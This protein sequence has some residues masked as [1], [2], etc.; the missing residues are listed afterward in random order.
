MLYIF[1]P[2]D[3]P[4]TDLRPLLGGKG[5]GLLGI[6]RAGLKIATVP[7]WFVV[8][9]FAF[10]HF[11]SPSIVGSDDPRSLICS[12]PF[13]ASFKEE[14]Q[15][16]IATLGE[17]PFAVRSS[18]VFEDG[19]NASFA[20]QLSSELFVLPEDVAQAVRKVWASSFTPHSLDYAKRQGISLAEIKVAV[21]VQQM[22]DADRA[23]VVFSCDPVTGDRSKTVISSVYGVGEGLVSGAL[24][25]D[26]FTIREGVIDRKLAYKTEAFRR[27]ADN[28]S[29]SRVEQVPEDLQ[30][31]AS[32]S[33]DE[34]LKI[35]TLASSLME[36]FGV[37]QDVEWCIDGKGKLY[38]LQSRPITSLASYTNVAQAADQRIIWDNSNIVESYSGV[39]TPLTFSFVQEVYSEVYRQFVKVMGVDQRTVDRHPEA[40]TMLGFIQGRIYYNL[41]SWHRLISLLPFYSLNAEFMEQ[42]MGVKDRLITEPLIQ[43]SSWSTILS[44]PSLLLNLIRRSIELPK[45]T[46]LFHQHLDATLE[47]IETTDRTA[48]EL[49]A[50]YR[51][52]ETALLRKWTTPIV[53]DF[54][55]M[56]FYGLLKKLTSKWLDDPDG[57]LQNDLLT[58]EGGIIS[59]E[60]I[61]WMRRIGNMI[62][63]DAHLRAQ[64]LEIPSSDVVDLLKSYT[65]IY[66]HIEQY[67]DK[68]GDRWSDELKIE[69]ITPRLR[70]S[71]LGG[72]IQSTVR[73]GY[74]DEV[75]SRDKELGIRH[76]AEATAKKHLNDSLLRREVFNFVLRQAR[77]RVKGRE[78]L[79][80]E[81]TRVFAAVRTIFRCIG[82]RFRDRELISDSSDI[83]YL[84]KNEIFSFIEGTSSDLDLRATVDRR[85]HQHAAFELQRVPNR[86]ETFGIVYSD[87][88]FAKSTS[89][90]NVVSTLQG[91]G[92]CAGIVRARVKI[93]RDPAS[94]GDMTGSI[95][96]AERTDPGWAPIFPQVSGIIVERGS[97][98]SHSAI[99]ARELG[100]PTVVGIT[101][102]MSILQDGE[103]IEIDGKLGIIRLLERE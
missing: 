41:L 35:A 28:G 97:L 84:T 34:I 44:M 36:V 79:R 102:L 13:D 82:D 86:L 25:S 52:L 2:K 47:S 103:M 56:I 10:A 66:A 23:G 29:G 91:Q 50:E 5:A 33:D 95:L 60:P 62:I 19:A 73:S 76:A 69:T 59:T 12:T 67:I 74:Y 24:D 87:N 71:L 81:R 21:I 98:L 63:A 16:A 3:D 100:I 49:L 20:G 90:E 18:A 51:K 61:R 1:S 6:E 77:E 48:S 88:S 80:F 4:A 22:I 39:T 78:N 92:C 40:F 101:D 17:G 26:T 83:F 99:V 43:R 89:P 30:M 9:S 8:T 7:D 94:A 45:E 54:F 32:L 55:V 53:N 46:T 37:P 42:M 31:I 96:A 64:V 57:T 70:P 58:G 85:K 27:N 14:L 65:D 11:V 75:A 68:F 15:S 93:V 72:M 38:V